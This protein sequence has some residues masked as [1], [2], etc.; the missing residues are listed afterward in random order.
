MALDQLLVEGF[1][2]KPLKALAQAGN[3]TVDPSWGALRVM[4]E[5]LIVKEMNE[6]DAKAVV[7]PIQKVHGLRT[8]VKGHAAAEKKRN[9]EVEARTKHGNFRAHFTQM[10][11]DCDKALNEVLSA[12]AIVIEK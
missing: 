11:A 5:V 12:F 3:R 1:L 8:E 6:Q 9:A 2:V 10:A 4:Q 7:A